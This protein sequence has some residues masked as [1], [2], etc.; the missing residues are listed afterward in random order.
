MAGLKDNSRNKVTVLFAALLQAAALYLVYLTLSLTDLWGYMPS[1]VQLAVYGLLAVAMMG[2]IQ[3]GLMMKSPWSLNKSLKAASLSVILL[4]IAA[5]M[6]GQDRQRLLEIAVKPRA[7]FAYPVPEIILTVSPPAHSGGQEYSLYLTAGTESPESLKPIAEGS[8]IRIRVANTAYAPTL[9]AGRNK[10][11]FLPVEDGGFM[12]QF[13]LKDEIIWQIREGSRVVARWPI[14]IVADDVPV[15]A[16]VDFRQMLTGD[17]LFALS[18]HLS[19]DYGLR[20]VVI[21][22]VVPQGDPDSLHDR[23][24]LDML[25]L[26]EFSG[27]LYVNFAASD[28]AGSRVDLIVEVTDQAGQKQQKIL[29]GINLPAK[30]FSNPLSRDIIDI[31]QRLVS[32]PQNRK[33]LARLLMVKGLVPDYGQIPVIYYMALRS[34]YWRL[35]KSQNEGDINSA[36]DIL[37]DI[38]NHMEDRNRNQFNSDILALLA[39]LKLALYQGREEGEIRKQ[40]QEIDKVI[41]LYL[42]AQTPSVTGP[43][44]SEKFDIKELRR[45]YGKI[46]AKSRHERVEEAIDLISY[47]EQGIIYRDRGIL[48]EQGFKRF[49]I[50]SQARNRVDILKK[51]QRQIMSFV[52]RNSVELELASLDTDAPGSLKIPFGGDIHK[53]IALQQKLGTN[54]NDLA[55]I[56]VNSRIN[57]DQLT[58]AVGDLIRDVVH[59]MEAGDMETAAQYQ[60][61]ILMLLDGLKKILDR[62]IK[63]RP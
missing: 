1:L 36:L 2:V 9:I 31:R 45:I 34:A 37:W 29:S 50:V 23:T 25:G 15:I 4:V 40:L 39:S 32:E 43:A 5:I 61:E 11:E 17:G 14:V 24:L 52:Y 20:Q 62:E 10:V 49:Q 54:V 38:A 55:R 58:V 33:R 22:V 59:S 46:L 60:S 53:W 47:L 57:S 41:T 19:D 8:K 35:V 28:L 26:K 44:D 16:R 12:A 27:E 56:L 3:R 18:L 48:S 21:G 63:Y 6:A 13:I 7:I 51:A 30:K 42:R